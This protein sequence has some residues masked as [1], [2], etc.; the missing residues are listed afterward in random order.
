MFLL[1][2]DTT[3]E[4]RTATEHAVAS[5]GDVTVKTLDGHG[6]MAHES[7]PAMVARLIVEFCR[8]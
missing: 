4:H 8:P 1:G 6:H 5:I 3:P 7:A 2:S